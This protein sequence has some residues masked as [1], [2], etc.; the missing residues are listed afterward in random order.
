MATICLGCSY[1]F[2]VFCSLVRGRKM[3]KGAPYPLGKFGYFIVRVL[4]SVAATASKRA[5]LISQNLVTVIWIT[6]SIVLFCMRMYPAFCA[7][8]NQDILSDKF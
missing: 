8:H 5:K 2:P 1:A 4:L 7:T 6:F 3:V